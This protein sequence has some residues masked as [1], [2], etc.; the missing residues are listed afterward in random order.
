MDNNDLAIII[1]HL[2]QEALYRVLSSLTLQSDK[3]FAIYG[4]CLRSEPGIKALFEDYA[5]QIDLIIC[6]VDGYPA[7]D[8]PPADR[9]SFFLRPL[10]NERFV[11]F[12]D[13]EA[14]Y[15][16]DCIRAFHDRIRRNDAADLFRWEK[17]CCGA[18]R[19]SF[20]RYFRR[21]ILG[22][23]DLPLSQVIARKAALERI[24][25]ANEY[26]SLRQVAAELAATGGLVRIPAEVRHPEERQPDTDALVQAAADRCSVIEW[27]EER[28]ER[29]WPVG[30]WQSLNRSADLFTNLV[31]WV[32]KE[33]ARK[34]FMALKMAEKAPGLA[35]TAFLLNSWGL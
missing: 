5:E 20:G 31:P 9:V 13:G 6:E 30:R 1:P 26:F 10:G 21:F 17:N 25:S 18:A 28:F 12:S 24:F 29:A 3:R 34:R 15:D 8:E 19:L 35:R 27:A 23:K 33:E 11:S 2:G 7:A 14:I 22:E 32:S 16:R 4:F